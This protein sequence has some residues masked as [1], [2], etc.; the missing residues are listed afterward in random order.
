VVTTSGGVALVLKT[1]ATDVA[2][3]T[4]SVQ[5][6][7]VPEQAPSQPENWLPLAGAAVRTTE[8]A[9]LGKQSVPQLPLGHEIFPDPV[10]RTRIRT[11]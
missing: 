5:M 6:V 9:K 1:A 8:P 10:P 7:P 2:P 11:E 3:L 4:G